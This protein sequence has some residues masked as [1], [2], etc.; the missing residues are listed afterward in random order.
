M[1]DQAEKNKAIV[2]RWLECVSTGDLAVYDELAAA[3]YA[4]RD[5]TRIGLVEFKAMMASWRAA[6]PDATLTVEDMV[7]EGDKVAAR[8]SI[9]GTH[10]GPILGIPATGKQ[11]E[12]PGM[13][14]YRVAGGKIVDEWARDDMLTM[15]QQLGAVRQ[16]G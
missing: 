13:A 9:R 4:L 11:V 15:L 12:F 6:F 2:R 5:A 10:K 14:M 7:A 1:A 16:F 8:F 3:D